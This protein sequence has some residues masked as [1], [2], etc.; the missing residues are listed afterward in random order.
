M[1]NVFIDWTAV[2][3]LIL[4]DNGRNI[5]EAHAG[6]HKTVR[7]LIKEDHMSIL[8]QFFDIKKFEIRGKTYVHVLTD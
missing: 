5:G 1:S 7:K 3:D 2:M 4:V 8:K 6:L